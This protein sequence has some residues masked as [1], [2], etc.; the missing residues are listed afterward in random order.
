MQLDQAFADLISPWIW[1]AYRR[2]NTVMSIDGDHIGITSMTLKYIPEVAPTE[3]TQALYEA[4]IAHSEE[5]VT[6]FLAKYW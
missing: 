3:A 2:L 6:E 4:W 1:P 5:T